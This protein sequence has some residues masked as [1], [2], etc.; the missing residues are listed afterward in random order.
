V[1][2]NQLEQPI[3][4]EGFLQECGGIGK[5]VLAQALFRDE[6]VRQAFPDGLVW[7]TVGR[8]PTHDLTA[9]L[10]EIISCSVAQAM[11]LSRLRL[12]TGLPSSTKPPSS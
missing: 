9:R 5:T 8:E 6:V 11:K 2:A 12:C 4:I 7:I 10:R 1:F 3:E